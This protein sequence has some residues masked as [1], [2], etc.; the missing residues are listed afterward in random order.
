MA[1][2][3][4]A[5]ARGPVAIR[6]FEKRSVCAPTA[7]ALGPLNRASPRTSTPASR[8]RRGESFR[9][10]SAASAWVCASHGAGP[11]APPRDDPATSAREATSARDV[12]AVLAASAP[13]GGARHCE[14]GSGAGRSGFGRSGF[15]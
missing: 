3:C 4:S 8:N 14:L 13:A 1:S 2:V 12:D 15:G 10:I 9:P 11:S 7:T 5:A 6:V